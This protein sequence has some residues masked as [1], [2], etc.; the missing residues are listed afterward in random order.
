VIHHFMS[1]Q[2]LI[3][4]LTGGTAAAINFFSRIFYSQWLDFS[5]AVIVAYLT[6]MISAFIFAK[7]FVFRESK[8]SIGRSILFFVLVNFIAVLQTWCIS[9]VLVY[10]L[11]PAFGIDK[12]ALEI[13]HAIGVAV[14][15]FTSYIG[16][17]RLSFR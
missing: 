15:V 8:Q 16:H 2:F 6:G 9:M 4:L 5:S 13:A 10:Y 3:F 12:F 1:R 7:I 17:K 11:L 14:P